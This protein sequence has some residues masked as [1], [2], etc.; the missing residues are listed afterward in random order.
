MI[1]PKK[2]AGDQERI[3]IAK[4]VTKSWK[5]LVTNPFIAKNVL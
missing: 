4:R 3:M 5:N 2:N 1:V